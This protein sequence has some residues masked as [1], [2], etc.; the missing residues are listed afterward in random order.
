MAGI[1]IIAAERV[2]QVTDEG[3][4]PEHDDEYEKGEMASAAACYASPVLIY[5]KHDAAN[6]TIYRDPWPWDEEWDKRSCDGNV[7]KPNES[8]TVG[9]RIKMLAKAGALCA[10]EIDRLVRI[11]NNS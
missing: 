1:D 3:W 6:A 4:T 2:R 10:A 5:V 7:V 8:A 9:K 11:A